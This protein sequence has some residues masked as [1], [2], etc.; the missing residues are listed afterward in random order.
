MVISFSGNSPISVLRHV[1]DWIGNKVKDAI[2][3]LLF[4]QNDYIDVISELLLMPSFP[5]A[6]RITRV[7]FSVLK[8]QIRC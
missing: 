3:T 2:P 4:R 1:T 6:V 5:P 8:F 7:S